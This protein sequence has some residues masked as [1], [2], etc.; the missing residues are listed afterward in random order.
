MLRKKLGLF[1]DEIQDGSGDHNVSLIVGNEATGRWMRRSP[2]DNPKALATTIGDWLHNWKVKKAQRNDYRDVKARPEIARGE[3][4]FRSRCSSCHSLGAGDGM[5]PDLIGVTHK[6]DPAWLARWI[7]VPDEMLAEEDPLAVALFNQYRQ[8]PMPN[9][10][11]NDVDVA[12]VIDFIEKQSG[13]DT[14]GPAK[15]RADYDK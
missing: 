7:A 9:L 3:Y 11:L 5:G 15:A 2:F 14:S 1:I 6:R 13:G 12:A 4:L 8:L 10:G